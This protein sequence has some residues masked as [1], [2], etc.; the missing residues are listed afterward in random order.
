MRPGTSLVLALLL[1]L[2]VVSLEGVGLSLG[3][4]GLLE[5]TLDGI[6]AVLV[7][8]LQSRGDVLH[9]EE[10]QHGKANGGNEHL[11]PVGNEGVGAL[12]CSEN[13]FRPDHV[14]TI[15]W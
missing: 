9:H 7:G 3:L 1:L 12:G 13:R 14:S 5:T 10:H 15:L 4:L 11:P 6:D 8:V 2:L